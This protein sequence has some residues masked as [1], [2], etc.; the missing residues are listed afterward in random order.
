MSAANSSPRRRPGRTS[1]EK[2]PATFVE[3]VGYVIKRL[4]DLI[5]DVVG[6]TKKVLH[7]SILLVAVALPTSS[8]FFYLHLDPKRWHWVLVS[9][10]AT[11][12]TA[13]TSKG[14]KKAGK[15]I[16]ARRARKA[17]KSSA[18]G[19]PQDDPTTP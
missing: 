4:F 11:A 12:V 14:A 2:L 16:K 9:L 6:D 18:P 10:G 8:V 1:Q 5:S 3:L 7:A 13:Y 17:V 19:K 15:A